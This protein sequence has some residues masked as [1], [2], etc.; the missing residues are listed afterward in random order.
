MILSVIASFTIC[1]ILK[2]DLTRIPQEV[3]PFVFL[4]IGPENMYVYLAHEVLS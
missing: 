1:A 3:Y 4:G 2:V